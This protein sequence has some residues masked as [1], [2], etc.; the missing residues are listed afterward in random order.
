MTDTII[1]FDLETS[2]LDSRKHEIIQIAAAAYSISRGELIDEFAT[3]VAFDVK[4]AEPRALEVNGYDPARWEGAPTCFEALD[5][6]SRWLRPHCAIRKF[7]ERARREYYVAL[8]AGYNAVKFDYPWIMQKSKDL[9]LFIPLDPKILDVMQL[10]L[11]INRLN[12]AQLEDDKQVT[13]CAHHGISYEA[14]TALGDVRGMAELIN[15]L[16]GRNNDAKHQTTEA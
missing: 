1:L 4:R 7:S 15:A 11:W 12:G 16:T 3:N 13:V 14:H 2:G 8:G 6:W 9:G 10:A 5:R